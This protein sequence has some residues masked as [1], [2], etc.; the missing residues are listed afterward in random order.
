MGHP[1]GQ[2]NETRARILAG[3][4]RV[5][6]S[7]GYGASGVDGLAQAAG[8]TSGA[9]YKHFSSKADVFRDTVVAGLRELASGIRAFRETSPNG[10]VRRFVD[11][12]LSDRRTCSL[13]ESCALQSLTAEVARANDETRDAYGTELQEVIEAAAEGLGAPSHA[14]RR[15]KTIVLL[16]LLTGGVSLA[17]AVRDPALAEEITEAIRGA[18]VS[19]PVGKTG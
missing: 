9:F 6:R 4:G 16:A 17:R 19:L 2:K 11:F 3:A 13:A 8:V 5:F 18:C 12:Y 10:W 15:K 14:T 7:Y 1:S